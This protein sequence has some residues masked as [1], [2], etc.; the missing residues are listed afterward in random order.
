MFCG[1]NY[2]YEDVEISLNSSTNKAYHEFH[3]RMR[4][5]KDQSDIET[6]LK[7]GKY[8]VFGGITNRKYFLS[9]E[10]INQ[11]NLLLSFRLAKKIC[12]FDYYTVFALQKFSPYTELFSDYALRLVF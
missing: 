7:S 9:Y 3:R 2:K 8:G 6:S 1:S 4:I 11:L 12:I 5:F 10:W